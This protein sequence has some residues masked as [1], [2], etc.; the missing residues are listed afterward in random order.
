[1]YNVMVAV[2]SLFL[3]VNSWK[4]QGSTALSS[5]NFMK[6]LLKDAAVGKKSGH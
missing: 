3:V 5:T 4:K 2:T 1:M 6:S